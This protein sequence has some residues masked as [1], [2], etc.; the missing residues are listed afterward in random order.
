MPFFSALGVTGT[1]L[2]KKKTLRKKLF[3]AFRESQ[4]PAAN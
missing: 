1:Y 4:A 3:E 2:S